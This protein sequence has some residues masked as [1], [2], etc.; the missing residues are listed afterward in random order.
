MCGVAETALNQALD[1]V[2]DN[3]ATTVKVS[4][5]A[6]VTLDTNIDEWSNKLLKP[7]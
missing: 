7:K 2:K 6:L 4:K 1:D 3:A 5:K